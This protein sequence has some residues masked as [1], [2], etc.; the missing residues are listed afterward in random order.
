MSRR[1]L[2]RGAAYRPPDSRAA[3][4]YLR[5]FSNKE[6]F[7][8]PDAF[9]PLDSHHL[10]GNDLPLHLEIGCGTAEFLCALAL[11]D[12][13]A[14]FIGVDVATKPLFKAVRN[15]ARHALPNIAFVKAD[16]ARLYP[17]LVDGSLQAI[18]LHFPDPHMKTRYRKRRVLTSLFLDQ[19]N[20][21]LAP[22]GLLSIMTDHQAF[23]ME[24]LALL[25]QDGRFVRTH[26][27]RYLVGFEPTV[28]SYF[29]RL[30]EHHGLPTFRVELRK[31]AV[32]AEACLFVQETPDPAYSAATAPC[33]DDQMSPVLHT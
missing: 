6:L 26:A 5:C 30:W 10:F 14:N 2:M 16:I 29:Q 32:C 22:G 15:A 27:E 3:R 33:T 17:L 8:H 19:A 23:F 1:S 4:Q 24:M 25:E 28:K 9:P 12:P 11:D 31:T 20:R 13:G 7:S 18:Y 21:V